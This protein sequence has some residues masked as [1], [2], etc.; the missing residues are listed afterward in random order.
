M[1]ARYPTT[2]ETAVLSTFVAPAVV[3]LRSGT[4]HTAGGTPSQDFKLDHIHRS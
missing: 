3:K 1:E 4:L 2:E